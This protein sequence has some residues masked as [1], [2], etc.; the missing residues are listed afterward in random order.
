MQPAAGLWPRGPQEKAGPAVSVRLGGGGRPPARRG[1]EARAVGTPRAWPGVPALTGAFSGL[2]TEGARLSSP[3]CPHPPPRG[4]AG[5]WERGSGGR[6]AGPRTAAPADPLGRLA[7]APGPPPPTLRGPYVA[8]RGQPAVVEGQGH[9]GNS[10]GGH[11]DGG[12]PL[13]S[14]TCVRHVKWAARK[15]GRNSASWHPRE[16]RAARPGTEQSP[17]AQ[18]RAAPFSP[19]PALWASRSPTARLHRQTGLAPRPRAL[20]SPLR[21]AAR[22]RLPTP[23]H[24][25]REG[26]GRPA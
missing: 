9:Q 22:A 4:S 8:L 1:R 26:S 14:A 7:D 24:L 21:N 20:A 18:V 5:L 11:Q 25:P 17:S 23:P 2:C 19:S 6:A 13:W 12:A 10:A 16:G 3:S 15:S